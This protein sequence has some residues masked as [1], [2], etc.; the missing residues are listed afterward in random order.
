MICAQSPVGPLG[1]DA[2]DGAVTALVWGKAGSL[3][4]G[5]LHRQLSDELAAYFAGALKEFTVPLAPR[6]NLFQQAFYAALSEIPYG[7]T[8]TYGDLAKDLGVSAQAI[9]QACGANP[10]AILIPCHRVLGASGLGGYSGMGG[11]EAKVAL[12]KLEGAAGLLI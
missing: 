6:G 9:G 10:I 4:G 1:A 11:V 8:R 7:E 12:L 2:A 5:P 3:T